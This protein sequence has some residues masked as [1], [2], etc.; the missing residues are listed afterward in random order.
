MDYIINKHK[1]NSCITYL[2]AKNSN[3]TSYIIKNSDRIQKEYEFYKI[4]HPAFTSFDTYYDEVKPETIIKLGTKTIK[5][6]QMYDF[7]P[8]TCTS[9][10][11]GKL[12]PN[13]ITLFDYR[14]KCINTNSLIELVDLYCQILTVKDECF[15]NFG[16]VHGDFKSNNILIN[17]NDFK[18]IQFIDFEFSICFSS[19]DSK[20]AIEENDIILYLCVPPTFEITGEFG[21]IFDIYILSLEL[22]IFY[23]FFN[24]FLL[25]IERIFLYGNIGDKP[26]IFVDFF[27]ILEMIKSKPNTEILNSSDNTVCAELFSIENTILQFNPNFGIF[28][29]SNIP[30][31]ESRLD[32]LKLIIKSLK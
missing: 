16:F 10:L 17:P 14:H 29:P 26:N 11:L 28:D 21:R 13:L 8:N 9:I 22:K 18:S 3:E 30:V 4:E 20:I 32:H 1:F 5:A 27:L 15:K 24:N 12:N 7:P 2:N 6:K 23:K 31:L 25:E 19:P